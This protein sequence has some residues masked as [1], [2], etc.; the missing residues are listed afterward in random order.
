MPFPPFLLFDVAGLLL[1]V[2]ARDRGYGS[3]GE[4]SKTN[5]NSNRG[6]HGLWSHGYAAAACTAAILLANNL[7][8][9]DLEDGEKKHLIE[10]INV[11]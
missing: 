1:N 7:V 4:E 2:H 5:Y 8:G 9:K 10:S 3:D 6:R 11:L